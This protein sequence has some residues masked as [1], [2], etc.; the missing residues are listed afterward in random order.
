MEP[1]SKM[2][3]NYI[4]PMRQI[5]S[6]LYIAGNTV[7][8]VRDTIQGL[9]EN[10]ARSVNK[11]QTNITF[12]DVMQGYKDVILEGPQNIMTISKLN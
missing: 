11:Y 4:Q 10:I 2:I 1:T 8:A 3:D 5:N 12:K 6:K 9:F 7:G